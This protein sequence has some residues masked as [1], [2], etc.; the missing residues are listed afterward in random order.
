M[1][2]SAVPMDIDLDS[3]PC[4]F[5]GRTPPELDRDNPT[6]VPDKLGALVGDIVADI[7]AHTDITKDFKDGR[8]N[9]RVPLLGM[10]VYELG[11]YYG[12]VLKKEIAK[13]PGLFT[14]ELTDECTLQWCECD[15]RTPADYPTKININ[16]FE[17]LGM[18]IDIIAEC[19]C[20]ANAGYYEW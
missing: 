20:V 11:D 15:F 17:Y 6:K 9:A 8:G 19:S 10:V 5:P 7:R 2:P 12:R 3:I 16:I 18:S 13:Y 1:D 14:I 4:A